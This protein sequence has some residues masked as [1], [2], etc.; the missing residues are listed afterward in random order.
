MRLVITI[1]YE[2]I[3]YNKMRDKSS[4]YLNTGQY[5]IIVITT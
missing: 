4:Q 5:T 3:D 1:K 2:I